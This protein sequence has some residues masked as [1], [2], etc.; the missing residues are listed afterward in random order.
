MNTGTIASNA[1]SGSTRSSTA[2][3]MPP[4]AEAAA[5]RSVRVRWPSSSR[6]YPTAPATDPGTSPIVFET[7]AVTG[8]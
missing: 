7:F 5:K 2:P 3:V 4:S 8:E 1:D 6:L